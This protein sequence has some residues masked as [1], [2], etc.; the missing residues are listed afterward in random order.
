[1]IGRPV[2]TMTDSSASSVLVT[3]GRGLLGGALGSLSTSDRLVVALGR[4]ELDIADERSVRSAVDRY[5]PRVLVNPAAMT[6]VDGC[7]RDPAAARRANVD[8]PRTLATVCRAAGVR[9][10]HIS[11]DFVFDGRKREP[12]TFE[13]VPN[14]LSIYG[15]TKLAGEEAVRDICD[16]AL[17]V[18]VAWVFGVGGRN[19]VSRIFDYAAKSTTLRGITDMRSAP[20]YA[21]ELAVR[22]LELADRGV[23]GTYHVTGSGDATWFDVARAALDEAGRTDVELLPTTAAELGL[24]AP[25]PAY[26]VMRCLLSERLGL[27]P[28]R[29]WREAIEDFVEAALSHRATQRPEA[30]SSAAISQGPQ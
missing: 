24:P 29:P 10:V 30:P 8:G 28:L 15:A 11:T 6:D 9:L 19:F 7:E 20:T 13:D 26:S 2:S 3:G 18:R 21:P 4:D 23:S 25:R 17:V 12:Y 27:P 22:L 1:M 16:D 5:R 14:P